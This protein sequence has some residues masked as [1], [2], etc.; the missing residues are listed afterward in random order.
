MTPWTIAR[1][2]PLTMEFSRQEFWRELTFPTPGDSLNLG[3]EPTPLAS[4]DW[5]ADSLPL[6]P[7]WKPL[8]VTLLVRFLQLNAQRQF[9]NLDWVLT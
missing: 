3:I 4:P 2:A 8:S 6:A 7:P 5:Q 9:M 1:Q